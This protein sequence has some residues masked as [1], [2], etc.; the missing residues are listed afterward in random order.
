MPAE[1][2]GGGGGPPHGEIRAGYRI[3]TER[4]AEGRAES[5]PGALLRAENA[6]GSSGSVP[7]SPAP[8]E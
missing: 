3:Q 8:P 6:R 2:G 1:V 4:R 7:L 5:L